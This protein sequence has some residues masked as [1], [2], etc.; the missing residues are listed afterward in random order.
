MKVNESFKPWLI[1]IDFDGTFLYDSKIYPNYAYNLNDLK[2]LKKLINLGHKVT[3]LT[4]RSLNSTKNFYNLFDFEFVLSNY[5]GNLI[6]NQNDKTF[7]KQESFIKTKDLKSILK[8]IPFKPYN[9]IF[10][11][12]QSVKLTN[13]NDFILQEYQK[14]HNQNISLLDLNND[15]KDPLAIYLRFE[16]NF[17]KKQ[18]LALLET[19]FNDKYKF[20]FWRSERNGI[21]N[22]EINNKQI[23]KLS[24]VKYIANF[25]S[26]KEENII[27]FGDNLN[28][29][30]LLTSIKHGVAMKN[31]IKK[32]IDEA[33]Y[34]TSY[35][36]ND[37]GVVRFLETFF[38]LK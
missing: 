7:P 18:L 36:N 2:V 38:N 33:N 21:C 4:G 15:L 5:N 20:W 35:S 30:E 32:L 10:E 3:F 22:L 25:Y 12:E 31:G 11:Y 17:D 29:L 8:T 13:F 14:T 1:A 6:S 34:Q 27:A 26:I 28:D 37:S 9:I 24:A 23:N 16:N 19:K